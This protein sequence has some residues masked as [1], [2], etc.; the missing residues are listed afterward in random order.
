MQPLDSKWWLR[1]DLNHRPHHYE[2]WRL[3]AL[4]QESSTYRPPLGGRPA[5]VCNGGATIP[6][7]VPHA[8]AARERRA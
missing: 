8:L 3:A 2:C 6:A 4:P 5:T 1:V 7:K